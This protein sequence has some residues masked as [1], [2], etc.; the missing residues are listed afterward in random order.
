MTAG[1]HKS[2]SSTSQLLIRHTKQVVMHNTH[3][4]THTHTHTTFIRAH[5]H[6]HTHKC[7]H[8]PGL[9]VTNTPTSMSE[10]RVRCTQWTWCHSKWRVCSVWE[11]TRVPNDSVRTTPTQSSEACELLPPPQIVRTEEAS[12]IRRETSSRNR[13]QDQLPTIQ[14]FEWPWTWMTENLHQHSVLHI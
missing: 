1:G 3:T 4:H 13:N 5:F 12:W 14:H 8:S 6:K 7:T 9:Y 11:L 2:S 10:S